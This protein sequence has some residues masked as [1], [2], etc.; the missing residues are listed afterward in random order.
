MHAAPG[1]F[2]PEDVA[3]ETSEEPGRACVDAVCYH[4]ERRTFRPADLGDV[5]LAVGVEVLGAE[6]EPSAARVVVEPG[7]PGRLRARWDVGGGLEVD[8]LTRPGAR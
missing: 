3:W 4:G 7:E 6:E 2:G 1:T 8:A 5:V